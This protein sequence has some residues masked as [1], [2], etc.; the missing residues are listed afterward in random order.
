MPK[1]FNNKINITCAQPG[2]PVNTDLQI[3]VY[4]ANGQPL[5]AFNKP[6]QEFIS[7]PVI[8]KLVQSA[9]GTTI[10]AFLNFNDES[11]FGTSILKPSFVGPWNVLVCYK[12][13]DL[14]KNPKDIIA[15]GLMSVGLIAIASPPTPTPA[16]NQ[17]IIDP[18]SQDACTFQYTD[19]PKSYI[20]I[21]VRKLDSTTNPPVNYVWWWNE[22][23]SRTQDTFIASNLTKDDANDNRAIIIW[24]D[25]LKNL[26]NP[27]QESGHLF[28][29]DINGLRRTGANCIRLFFIS[30]QPTPGQQ[31]CSQNNSG[32]ATPQPS[33]RLSQCS[34]WA[35]SNGTPIPTSPESNGTQEKF[36][37][38]NGLA[39]SEGI[40]CASVSTAIGTISTDPAAFVKSIFTLVLGLSGG[41]ALILII[42]SGYRFMVSGGNPE[43]AKAAGEQ[44]TSA[45]IG[46]LFIIFSFV[47]LQII[48]VDILQIPGFTAK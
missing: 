6:G 4:P 43:A 44:L 42:I 2:C 27:R 32:T 45:I 33:P 11:A 10:N 30:S 48:G 47:I 20:S 3:I 37:R 18:L 34:I 26:T 24:G 8:S 14:C 39:S 9:D 1:N 36:I 16:P 5:S 22:G 13:S 17:P 41:I 31:A 12:T 19:D 25:K 21:K 23:S 35:Y 46:L 7:S 40:K 28:C 15:Q 29:T 38:D